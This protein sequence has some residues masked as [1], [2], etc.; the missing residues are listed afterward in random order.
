[1]TQ[2]RSRLPSTGIPLV[3]RILGEFARDVWNVLKDLIPFA[4]VE[5]TEVY[6]EP[7]Q[8]GFTRE[9]KAVLLARIRNATALET[10]VTCGAAVHYVWS[11]TKKAVI[12]NSID[13]LT[14]DGT[15]YRFTF[16]MVG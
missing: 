2:P 14:P 11:E 3:D 13:G 12:V 6:T 5:Y 4:L 7:M 10:P 1:M 16:L 8:L 9:P 15:R